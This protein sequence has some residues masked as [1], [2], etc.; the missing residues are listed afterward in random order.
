[1]PILLRQSHNWCS[2]LTGL[3]SFHDASFLQMIQLL[4]NCLTNGKGHWP[5]LVEHWFCTLL[6]VEF[7]SEVF[8]GTKSLL[9]HIL[10]PLQ[11]GVQ[12]A[13]RVLPILMLQIRFQ[14]KRSDVSQS[15]PRSE[16]PVPS[17]TVRVSWHLWF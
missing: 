5:R 17:T 3:D 7:G 16:D 10:I 2:L 6:D 9:E 11:Q 4:T 1:M 14:S 8:H 13:K 15:R 12:L